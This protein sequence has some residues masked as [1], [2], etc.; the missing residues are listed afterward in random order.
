MDAFDAI[1]DPVV[2]DIL[3][4]VRDV[5]TLIRCRSV[6]KRFNS[7][8]TESDSLLLQLDQI[9]ESD[10]EKDSAITS[11]FRSLFK[12]VHGFFPIFSKPAKIL[13]PVQILAGFD[14]I[15]NLD[16][17]F[18]GGDFKLEKGAAVKWKAEFGESL[19]SCVIVAFRSA[20]VNTSAIDGDAETDSEFVSGLK[21]RVVWTISALMAASTRH[22]Q[23]RDLVKEH[24]EME[25]LTVR[26]RDGE[27]TVVMDAA[28][29][30]E[31]RETEARGDE[32][33]SRERTVVPN[34][35]MSMRN[36][37]S[38][39]LKS[40]I[41]LEAAT[42]VVVRPSGVASDDDD[43]ELATGAFGFGDCMYG[44]AV[45]ALLKRMRNVLEMNSF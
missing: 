32:K 18:Y 15:R 16:V 4:E 1:P 5:K 45:A 35:R 12:S 24:K 26:D 17:K 8:A 28:G 43:A 42:L 30:K 14:Q 39:K 13:T 3:N 11:F 31:Y 9:G 22:Y 44:E 7:L 2:I 25:R 38:L 33:V 29:M 36:A 37:P 41:C 10:S 27:G 19:K 21:T 23:M 34:V 6:S 40:G 20:T